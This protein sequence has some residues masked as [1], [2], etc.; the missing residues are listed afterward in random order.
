MT[1]FYFIGFS[2]YAENTKRLQ[3]HCKRFVR[4]YG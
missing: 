1:R 3:G 2:V 4:R